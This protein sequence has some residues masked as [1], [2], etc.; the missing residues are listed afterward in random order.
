MNSK[1]ET[2]L[3]KRR[4]NSSHL[5]KYVSCAARLQKSTLGLSD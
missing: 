3:R 4:L 2:K 1:D 5:N